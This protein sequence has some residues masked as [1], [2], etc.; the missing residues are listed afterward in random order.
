[1]TA[2]EPEPPWVRSRSIFPGD[3]PFWLSE[4]GRDWLRTVFLPF[5]DAL[6]SVE[7]SRYIER[8]SAPTPWVTLFLHPDMDAHMADVDEADTGERVAPLNFRD[9]FLGR[10]GSA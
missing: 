1:M 7:Q 6:S 4:T 8:W 9:R 3:D 10:D 2:A 5:Y